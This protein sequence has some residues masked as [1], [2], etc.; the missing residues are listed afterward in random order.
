MYYIASFTFYVLF[1]KKQPLNSNCNCYIFL[2]TFGLIFLLKEI[3]T[4]KKDISLQNCD[5]V[6]YILGKCLFYR[7]ILIL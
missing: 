5:Q 6:T 3:P 7:V 4:S 1:E 2:C